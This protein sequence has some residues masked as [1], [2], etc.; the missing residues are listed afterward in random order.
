MSGV[1][2]KLQFE[3]STTDALESWQQSV[4]DNAINIIQKTLPEKIL[5]LNAKIVEVDSNKKHLFSK[6]TYFDPTAIGTD[7][8]VYYSS[9]TAI[10]DGPSNKKRK[11]ATTVDGHPNGV[12]SSTSHDDSAHVFTGIVHSPS[13]LINAFA[14]L[15]EEWDELIETMDALK[16]Y[17]N[18]QMPQIEDGD[19]FGVSIQEEALNEIVRTQDSAYNLIA[20]PFTYHS[21]RG[22]LA[23]K[24]VRYPGVKDYAEAI[25]EYDRKSI[26]RLKM[27]LTDMRNMY[28][29]VF[30]IVKKN[31]AKISKPKSGNQMGSYG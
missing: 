27:H 28:A 1:A 9:S 2:V 16:M 31:I 26:Y 10:E 18:L 15:R 21:A 6:T 8:N 25:R 7:V 3:K 4:R 19:T 30:D 11:T 20:T 12:S 14:Q 13:Y 29:V 22:D 24:L 17:I 5:S 23:A